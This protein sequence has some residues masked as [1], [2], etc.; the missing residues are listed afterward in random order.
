MRKFFVTVAILGVLFMPLTGSTHRAAS[1]PGVFTALT[2]TPAPVGAGGSVSAVMGL[3]GAPINFVYALRGS[4]TTDFWQYDITENTWVAL[5]NTPAPVDDGGA[6]IQVHSFNICAQR[7]SGF[8]IAALRG[9]N[10]QDFWLYDIKT[11]RWCEASDTPAPVG[12]GGAL[13]QTQGSGE[14]F[15]FRGGATADFWK[16]DDGIWSKLVDAPGP[17]QAGAGLVGINHG[18][19]SGKPYLYALLGGGSTAVWRFDLTSKTWSHLTDAPGPISS[20]GAI[21]SSNAG[22]GDEGV[23]IILQGGDST[24]VWNLDVKTTANVW[25]EIS[26]APAPVTKGGAISA[27]FNGCSFG[28]V[29][30]GSSEFFSTGTLA[31]FLVNPAPD[32]SL[33]FTQPTVTVAQPAKIK[34]Q[35]NILRD[36]GFTGKITLGPVSPKLPGIIVPEDLQ[37]PESDSIKFKIKIKPGAPKGTFPLTFTGVDTSGRVRNATLTLVVE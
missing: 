13:A 6:M 33:H 18:T 12:A 3:V 19:N 10:T 15:A 1:R 20:G 37:L 9:G 2:P 36:S 5:A 4:G 16:F 28:L 34:V 31:C 17:V 7:D 23:L 21:T 8:A 27:Q 11:N 22:S 35:L 26:S 29:G 30:G 32:F 24:K 14:I 25:R